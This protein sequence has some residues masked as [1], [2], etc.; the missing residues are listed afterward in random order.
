M[1]STSSRPSLEFIVD[2]YFRDFKVAFMKYYNDLLGTAS[3]APDKILGS[4]FD[5]AVSGIPDSPFGQ[6]SGLTCAS[7]R[8]LLL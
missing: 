7:G 6:Y 4:N 2:R 5:N 1:I 3:K 8:V